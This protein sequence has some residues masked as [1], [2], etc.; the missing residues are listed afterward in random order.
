MMDNDSDIGGDN[1]NFDLNNSEDD[2]L[3]AA[4]KQ[5]SDQKSDKND[6]SNAN[7][8]K[9]QLESTE[10][11]EQQDMSLTAEEEQKAIEEQF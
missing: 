11:P 6:G 1:Y 8:A 2:E 7:P 10:N 4:I 5:D 9:K 3:D